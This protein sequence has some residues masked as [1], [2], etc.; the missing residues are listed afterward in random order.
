MKTGEIKRKRSGHFGSF[1]FGTF[2]GFLLTIAL[3]AGALAF[4]YFNIS[5]DWV[6]K[7]FNTNID[8][9]S[10][11]A[12]SLT[13]NDVVAHLS[14]IV[15]KINSYSLNDLKTDFGL[16]ID[17]TIMGIDISD[18]KSGPIKDLLTNLQNKLQTITA[19]ELDNGE[20]G[21]FDLSGMKDL[22]ETPKTYYYKEDAT[23]AEAKLYSN[24][25]RTTGVYS[26]PLDIE[27]E[28]DGNGNLLIKGKNFEP[29]EIKTESEQDGQKG[30]KYVEIAPKFLPLSIAFN[31]FANLS[32]NLKIK[33]LASYGVTLPDFLIDNYGESPVTSLDKIINDLHVYEVVG[34]KYEG[35]KFLKKGDDGTYTELNPQ[36]S[37]LTKLI[38]NSKV[39]DVNSLSESLTASQIFEYSGLFKILSEEEFNNTTVDK[40]PEKLSNKFTNA[41]ISELVAAGILEE[42]YLNGTVAGVNISG[43]SINEIL[44]KLLPQSRD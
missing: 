20:G 5:V 36:P 42:R 29:F 25:D 44:D 31:S 30:Y 12:N 16:I 26:E 39:M 9:K 8:L 13:L 1:F 4:V 37:K 10:E 24:F 28:N 6:N 17:D 32:E 23:D 33:D 3:L 14:G 35:D 19:A 38:L 18:L 11:Q 22:L 2:I 40:L 34:Y 15:G 7:H 41:K 21:L 27:V 43:L